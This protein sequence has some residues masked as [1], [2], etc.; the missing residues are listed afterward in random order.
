MCKIAVID[1]ELDARR[2]LSRYLE[3]YVPEAE[4]IGEANGVSDAYD[5]ILHKEPDI[6]LLDIHM[7]DGNGFE[8]LEK[9]GDNCPKV[10]FTTAFDEYALQAFRVQAVDYLLKPI[11]PE[12]LQEAIRRVNLSKEQNA[13]TELYRK[14]FNSDRMAIPTLTGNQFLRLN[15][16]VYV[17]AQGAYCEIN[18][19]N[20][21]KLLISKNLKFFKEK[22]RSKP[23]FLKPHKSY[24]VNIQYV[25]ALQKDDGWCLKLVNGKLIPVARGKRTEIA[26]FMENYFL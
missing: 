11:D 13:N 5:L 6:I 19:S 24:M 12:K 14:I 25:E 22:L 2:I 1:D 20:G 26:E 9:L 15:E 17:E 16:I 23:E 7:D 21:K 8:L 4:M 18:L 3:K 10:I